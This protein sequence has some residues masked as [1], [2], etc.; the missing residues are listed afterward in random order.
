MK[1]GV[2]AVTLTSAAVIGA[3]AQVL[4]PSGPT[5]P[6]GFCTG[7]PFTLI[8]GSARVHVGLDDRSGAAPMRVTVRLYDAA[9]TIVASRTVTLAAGATA[10]LE[11]RGAGL[12]RPQATFESL[13][14]PGDRRETVGS[15]ELHD[16][17]NFRAVIPIKCVPNENIGR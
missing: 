15:V 13:V 1:I 2:L 9:G 3:D 17:D 14:N 6:P 12:F 16:I 5:A 10:T 8:G 11:F 4:A 7:G